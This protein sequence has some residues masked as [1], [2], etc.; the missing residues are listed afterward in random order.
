MTK[1][2]NDR[3][4]TMGFIQKVFIIQQN[5]TEININK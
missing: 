5:G 4:Y 2:F 1:R 3:T